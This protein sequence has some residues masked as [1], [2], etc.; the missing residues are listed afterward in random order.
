MPN[1]PDI[2]QLQTSNDDRSNKMEVVEL[3]LKLQPPNIYPF[4][5]LKRVH[6]FANFH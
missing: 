5:R 6:I 4:T 1:Y 3:L 2:C